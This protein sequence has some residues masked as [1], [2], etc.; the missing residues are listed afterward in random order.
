MT[1]LILGL[2]E[3]TTFII[4]SVLFDILSF[5]KISQSVKKKYDKLFLFIFTLSVVLLNIFCVIF[6]NRYDLIMT[7]YEILGLYIYFGLIRK[8]N[9]K[10]ILG[11]AMFF[12]LVDFILDVGDKLINSLFLIFK[13]NSR[14]YLWDICLS[15]IGIVFVYRFNSQIRMYLTDVNSTIFLGIIIYLYFSI[16]LVN[17][18]LFFNQI[19]VEVANILLSLLMLQTIFAIV[20]YMGIIHIQREIKTKQQQL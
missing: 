17:N 7:L 20:L 15:I 19:P 10:L 1:N 4:I 11:S 8:N 5:N 6:F 9:K 18:Y 2:I 13:L 12:S 3:Q 14:I 16:E